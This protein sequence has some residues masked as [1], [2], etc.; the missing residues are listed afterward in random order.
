MI[1]VMTDTKFGTPHMPSEPLQTSINFKRFNIYT[2]PIILTSIVGILLSAIALIQ[3]I[4]A[5]FNTYD[6]KASVDDN[7]FISPIYSG[8]FVG[9]TSLYLL[10]LFGF[11]IL[12]Y[13]T[14]YFN[15][16]KNQDEEKLKNLQASG[17]LF[18]FLPVF[19]GFGYVAL[20][21]IYLVIG[22]ETYKDENVKYETWISS[23]VEGEHS[24]LDKEDSKHS[25]YVDSEA[26]FYK[27]TEVKVENNM[28]STIEKV[29]S[30]KLLEQ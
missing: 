27:V 24:K 3:S 30:P 14:L 25:W 29:D 10:S 26:N 23:N 15:F 19:I 7:K 8:D 28:V 21:F 6:I 13:C 17:S 18:H 22:L 20:V 2:K 9:F 5:A 16:G 4:V 12:L 1:D 11:S